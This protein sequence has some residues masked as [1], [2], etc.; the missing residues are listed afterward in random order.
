MLSCIM[1]LCIC[2]CDFG[3]VWTRIVSNIGILNEE[4]TNACTINDIF[5]KYFFKSRLSWTIRKKKLFFLYLTQQKDFDLEGRIPA[6]LIF[7]IF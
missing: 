3:P 6:L 4:L 7:F 2:F 1:D 5:S